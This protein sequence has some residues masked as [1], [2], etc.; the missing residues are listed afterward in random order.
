MPIDFS[1][2]PLR[3]LRKGRGLAWDP[4]AIDLAKDREDWI[5]L[6]PVSQVFLLRQVVGF[7]IGERGVTHDL[8]PLQQALRREKGRMEEEMY[9]TQQLYEESTHV[10]FFQRWMNEVLPGKLGTDIP[11]PPGQGR[12]FTE[13]LPAAMNALAEDPSP[14]AQ[15]RAAVTYHQ[16]IEGV[17][18]EIG[19]AIFYACL[20]KDGILP[21]LRQGIRFIQQDESRHIAFGTY[22]AQRLIHEHPEL[23]AVFEREMEALREETVGS[24]DGFF[25]HC[26]DAEPF[27]LKQAPFRKLAEDLYRRRI[28]SVLR[29]GLVEA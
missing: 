13:I 27:G 20:D 2:L 5:A 29:G 10:E 12:F 6:D 15:M 11:F 21:G 23:E 26:D 7:L 9:L 18:A 8:A 4:H 17:L 19:Y 22:L 3:E 28:R 24:T 16:I 25:S 14:E 1:T